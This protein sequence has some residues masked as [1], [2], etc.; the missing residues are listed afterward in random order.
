MYA[1][2]TIQT[3]LRS[4]TLTVP[5]DAVKQTGAQASVLIVDSSGRI[6]ARD[7]RLGIEDA[8]HAEV[9]S[10]L[11]EGDRVVVGN[12]SAYQ[13]GEVV[14]AKLRHTSDA[15]RAERSEP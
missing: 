3:E 2:V 8:D 15:D 4:N 9:L 11:N 14:N 6:Q 13:P 1:D 7:I 12:L 5:I 10:G